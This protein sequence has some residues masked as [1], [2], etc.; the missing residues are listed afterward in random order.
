MAFSLPSMEREAASCTTA[1]TGGTARE[2]RRRTERA[3]GSLSIMGK[4][5][6]STIRSGCPVANIIQKDEG[7]PPR[8]SLQGPAGDHGSIFAAQIR[9]G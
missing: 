1:I 4:V 7:R 3:V 9:T 8:M 6:R 5:T 2:L